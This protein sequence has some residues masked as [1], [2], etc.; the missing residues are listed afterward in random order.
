[1]VAIGGA[2]SDIALDESRGLLYIANF[3]AATIEKMS[4]SI[5]R[6]RAPSTSLPQPGALAISQDSQYLL[7]AHYA[8]GATSPPGLQSHHPHSSIR[9]VAL[10]FHHRRSSARR[11]FL[12]HQPSCTAPQ[13]LIVTTTSVLRFDPVSGQTAV[14]SAFANLANTLPVSQGTLPGQILQTAV[15]T[16]ADG[17]TV[18]GIGGANTGSQ[19][20]F[21]YDARVNALSGGAYVTSPPL[22]PRVSVAADGSSAMIGYSLGRRRW[23]HDRDAIPT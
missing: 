17:M 10:D 15:T 23:K 13:A 22:L 14:I 2:A 5:T 11:R 9:W 3:G 4:L 16:S 1:M 6:Y 21:K 12:L 18:W 7:V 19:V 8:N 20:V